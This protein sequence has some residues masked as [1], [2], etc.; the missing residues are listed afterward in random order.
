M[1]NERPSCPYPETG[2]KYW[3]GPEELADTPE[4]RA[5]V[6][7]EFPAG[8]EEMKDGSSRRD[9]V[10]LMSASFMLA[11]LGVF[12]VGCRRPEEEIL[13]FASQPEGYVHG[14]P[15]YYAT[16]MPTRSGA[17]PLLARSNDGRPTKVEGNA[18][19]SRRRCVS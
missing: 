10:K 1:K 2:A 15:Q 16:A 7:Q 17:I 18:I 12:G 19:G 13:P 4:F 8:A 11:G 5:W 6:E 14:V 3:R 9:F